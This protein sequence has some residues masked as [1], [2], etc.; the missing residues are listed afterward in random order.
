MDRLEQQELDSTTLRSATQHLKACPLCNALNASANRECFVCRWSGHFDHS[1]ETIEAGLFALF[2]TC[3]DLWDLVS[4]SLP[5]ARPPMRKASLL[6]R[7]AARFFRKR[8]DLL[9]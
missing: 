8:L 6:E 4:A 7:W 3:P 1:E 2:S 5:E 9:C